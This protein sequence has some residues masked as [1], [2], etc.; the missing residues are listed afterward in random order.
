MRRFLENFL[1]SE[2]CPFSLCIAVVAVFL[3]A[4]ITYGDSKAREEAEV[5]LQGIESGLLLPDT[6]QKVYV[7][8]GKV[9]VV[10]PMGNVSKASILSYRK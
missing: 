4:L 3:Y 10:D 7:V 9:Y 5:V 1:N 6:S 2:Y 8:G